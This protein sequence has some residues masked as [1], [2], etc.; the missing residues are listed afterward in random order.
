ME[1]CTH[2]FE[3]SKDVLKHDDCIDS[4]SAWQQ[5]DFYR[6]VHIPEKLFQRP[7]VFLSKTSIFRITAARLTH[8]PDRNPFNGLV[9]ENPCDQI[10]F[11][12]WK[13][14]MFFSIHSGSSINQS[15][16]VSKRFD[17]DCAKALIDHEGSDL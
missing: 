17:V 13:V 6:H 9:V 14:E 1:S 4:E 10:V 7:S 3:G 5:R 15:Y 2:W 16:H 8:Q 12:F 11:K